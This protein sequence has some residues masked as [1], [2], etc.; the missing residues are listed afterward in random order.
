MFP[1]LFQ[2]V[3]DKVVPTVI[4][5]LEVCKT[6]EEAIEILSF[7]ER[8]GEINKEYVLFLKNNPSLLISMIGKRRRG[9][10][11]KRGLL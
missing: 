11:E 6:I 7:F 2:E 8:A 9:E 1:N 4:D 10:Y 3:G 5:H